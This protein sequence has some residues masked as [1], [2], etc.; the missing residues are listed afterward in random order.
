MRGL[1]A[2]RSAEGTPQWREGTAPCGARAPSLLRCAESVFPAFVHHT[3]GPL[4]DSARVVLSLR[5]HT[6]RY[7]SRRGRTRAPHS[8]QP[9]H[10]CACPHRSGSPNVPALPPSC[11]NTFVYALYKCICKIILLYTPLYYYNIP[12]NT[13]VFA[14]ILLYTRPARFLIPGTVIPG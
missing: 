7:T 1:C 4:R 5:V 2:P 13:F 11:L 6:H 12:L 9:S 14:S 3:C 8:A 10:H